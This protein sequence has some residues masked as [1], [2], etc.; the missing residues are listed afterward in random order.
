MGL[1]K[2]IQLLAFLSYLDKYMHWHG[3]FAI[4]VRTTTFHQWCEEIEKWTDLVYIPYHSKPPQRAMLRKYQFPALDERGKPIE[5]AFSFN[6][7]L[8][9]Y[10][11]LLRD[12]DDLRRINWQVLVLDEGHR[13]KNRT[14]KKHIAIK[15]LPGKHRIILTGTPIQNTLRELWTLLGFVSPNHFTNDPEFLETELEDLTDDIVFGAKNL[16]QPHLLRRTIAEA[17]RSL[18]PKEEKIVFVGLSPVQKDLLRLVKLNKLW[19]LKGVPPSEED[20]EGAYEGGTIFK[21]CSHPF[22]LPEAEAFYGN[23]LARPRVDLLVS[24]SAKF[25]WLD[26]VL[27]VLHRDGHHV[28]LFSQRVELLKLIDEFVGL[29]GYSKLLLLGA[30]SGTE[31]AA[32]VDE[33]SSSEIFI[34]LISTRAGSEGLNLTAADTAIILD[35]DWNP[36]NDLQAQARCH[37]IGQTQKVDVLRVCTFQTYE[38][39]IFVRAQ[40]KLG[41]WMILLG[42]QQI[43]PPPVNQTPFRLEPPPPVAEI[44]DPG[45]SLDELLARSSTVVTDFSFH[46]LPWLAVSVSEG[47]DYSSGLSDDEFLQQF[48]IRT[49]EPKR[50]PKR[51]R[52]RDGQ[53]DRETSLE[54]VSRLRLFGFGQWEQI[55]EDI[56]DHSAERIRRFSIVVIILSFRAIPPTHLAYLPMLI[57]R[58]L[59]EESAFEYRDFLC[60]NKH[61][62]LQV[63]ADYPDLTMESEGAR[64]IR[65]ELCDNPFEILSIL[66]MRLIAERWLLFNNKD[67]FKWHEIAPPHSPARD[68]ALFAAITDSEPFDPF[69]LRVQAV[70]NR[71]RSDIITAEMNDDA[72]QTAWWSGIEFE[73]IVAAIKNFYLEDA[74]PLEIHARTT[75]LGKTTDSVLI[76]FQGFVHALRTRTTTGLAIPASLHQM[77]RAPDIVAKSKGFG[78]WTQLSPRLCDEILARM[79][80]LD[81]I[82]RKITELCGE[83]RIGEWGEPQ[84]RT[85]LETLLQFGVDSQKDLLI[86]ER[87]EFHTFLT[88]TD[89]EFVMGRKPRRDLLA[90]AVPD[91]LFSEE[92]L[93]AFVREELVEPLVIRL[94]SLKRLGVIQR[95]VK[96]R[97]R[98]KDDDSFDEFDETS[99]GQIG[100]GVSDSD[101][102]FRV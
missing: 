92:N 96:R 4:V 58:I 11:V 87:F 26:N 15:S 98:P 95:P 57:S 63:L 70:V 16:I 64:K 102:H 76:F 86:D 38:H 3:P 101:D 48:P 84:T 9:S 80:L 47:V 59:Q 62:W 91:C 14:G 24:M 89:I 55:A 28:L 67:A 46:T 88:T 41:L 44:D 20:T 17:E 18:A 75:I 61:S 93:R 12:V 39:Q 25:Q 42:S 36:Q 65:V 100:L 52:P 19:R 43:A 6:I 72:V 66:E 27:R 90:S 8:V 69:N 83:E 33:Y 40:R 2:T 31:K 34:F 49:E 30:M 13:I 5:N 53:L 35:P 56:E 1:G 54:I 99:D 50:R 7:L 74:P 71:M 79:A 37:R 29:R 23:G 21:I 94:P 22:L 77:R 85:F 32:A 68:R 81:G 60:T 73:A 10:D 97:T 51:Q 45:I 78:T 82:R